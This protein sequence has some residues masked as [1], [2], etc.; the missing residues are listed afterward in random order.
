MMRRLLIAA[1]LALVATA[2]QAQTWTPPVGVPMPEFR[3]DVATP[4]VTVTLGPSQSPPNPIPAGTHLRLQPGTYSGGAW[5]RLNAAGTASNPVFISGDPANRPIFVKEHGFTGTYAVLQDIILEAR[6]GN[7]LGRM[8]PISG[9]HLIVRR[10]ENRAPNYRGRAGGLQVVGGSQI[11]LYQNFVH[12]LGDVNA[13]TDQDAH[14]M[15]AGG[16]TQ[17]WIVDNEMA[18]CSGDGLQINAG[19]ASAQGGTRFIYVGRNDTHHHKQIGLWSKQA[20]DV[21]FSEN[22]AHDIVGSGSSTPACMGA[23]YGAERIWFLKNRLEHCVFGVSIQSTS[24][25]GSGVELG[26]MGNTCGPGV[27][28]RCYGPWP[29][30]H[31]TQWVVNNT[32]TAGGTINIETRNA[33]GLVI[34]NNAAAVVL[35]N[36]PG[37]GSVINNNQAQPKAGA[38]VPST[39]Y[40]RFQSLYGVD[41]SA[42]AAHIGAPTGTQPPPP[43]PPIDCVVSAWTMTSAG[44]WG[45]CSA[46]GTQTRDEVWGR[47]VTTQPANGGAACPALTETRTGT[48]ACTVEPPPTQGPP[49]PPGPQGPPGPAGPAGPQGPSGPI[50]PAGPKGDA[51]AVGPQG[52]AGADGA[53]GP[54]GPAGPQG[55]PGP[56]IALPLDVTFECSQVALTNGLLR[57][58]CRAVP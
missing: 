55:P 53:T 23:Q 48:Q 38:G 56:P 5:L 2:G 25:L 44:P 52:L 7:D 35:V 54:V 3:P 20:T 26:V 28:Q 45:A 17:V 47:T 43:P 15:T 32:A 57:L 4:P 6:S 1:A 51:G 16:A 21:I 30:T 14:C 27:T 12:D 11:V 18:R 31:R 9:S 22:Y 19:S 39:A 10:V 50:G 13:S 40:A 8:W 37:T 34:Q 33:T 49:G 24:G 36:G 42:W 41:L 46:A 58:V 29:D